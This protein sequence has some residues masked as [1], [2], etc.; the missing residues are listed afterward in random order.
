MADTFQF[1]LGP[2]TRGLP[3]TATGQ[4]LLQAAMQ[5]GAATAGFFAAQNAISLLVTAL[6]NGSAGWVQATDSSGNPTWAAS[7]PVTGGVIAVTLATAPDTDVISGTTTPPSFQ[8]EG[9]SYNIVGSFS[10]TVTYNDNAIWTIQ[11][12]VGLY[13]AVAATALGSYAWS[14]L[15]SPLLNGFCQGVKSCFAQA[16]NIE[17]AEDA[18]A[19]SEDAAGEAAVDET[20]AEGAEVSLESGGAAFIA[21]VVIVA[22]QYLL[23]KLD[24]TTYHY[25]RVYNLTPY[26]ITWQPP[27]IDD[28][29][30]TMISMPVSG[31]GSGSYDYV[32]PALS[33]TTPPG[34][35]S[36]DVASEASF[37]FAST[38]GY[39][40]FAY[41]LLLG[42]SDVASG[43]ALAE[44]SAL[45]DLPW[46]AHN[47]LYGSFENLDPE[48][49][50]ENWDGVLKQ[51]EYSTDVSLADGNVVTMT[52]TYDY[53][54]G[55]Q[56]APNGQSAYLYNS[57]LVFDIASS[58]SVS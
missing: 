55:E 44:S 17:S 2:G 47:S 40:G 42:L 46:G 41:V 50:F 18:A 15:V 5:G 26:Q 21:I 49:L 3:W 13:S 6:N 23:A 27:V 34:G 24:H 4:S 39:E 11:V 28:D 43:N 20:V 1:F 14:G 10:G 38:S 33:S 12:P 32:I 7:L 29:E 9:N 8:W 57:L 58:E 22:V 19:A 25:L 31:D 56:P 54:S 35:Q 36:V 37:A 53:I 52:M 48:S 51:T 16:D 30:A 45:F